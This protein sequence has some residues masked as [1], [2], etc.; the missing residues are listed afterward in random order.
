MNASFLPDRI[1]IKHRNREET[2]MPDIDWRKYLPF[3]G[4][5]ASY[6]LF[7]LLILALAAAF[8]WRVLSAFEV[9]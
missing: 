4:H 9:I 2:S 8:A 6:L 7:K 1:K 5:W 3:P